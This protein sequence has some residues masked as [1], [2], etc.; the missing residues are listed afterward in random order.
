MTK[1]RPV[2]IEIIVYAKLKLVSTKKYLSEGIEN[3]VGKEENARHQHIL[4]FPL[5]ISIYLFFRAVKT[6]QRSKPVSWGKAKMSQFQVSN[7]KRKR[8]LYNNLFTEALLYNQK[9]LK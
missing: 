5:D 7:I 2:Q 9:V 6:R 3:I 4:L 8:H 1:P